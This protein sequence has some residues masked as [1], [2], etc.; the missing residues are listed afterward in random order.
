[1]G[2]ETPMPHAHQIAQKY[3]HLALGWICVLLGV[4]GALLPVMPTT[5]F[6]ILAAFFF[7]K[8]SPRIRQWLI[9]H[10]T[11]G[12]PIQNW[13]DTKSIAPRIKLLAIGMMAVSLT[14]SVIFGLPL[15]VII[16]QSLCMSGASL[17][18]LTR[19]NA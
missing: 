2:P 17:Y 15:K 3:V 11:F 19:P 7:N 4:I 13:E 18:I 12:P 14:A 5:V 6:L 1:M 10:P 8:G 16:I 9:T